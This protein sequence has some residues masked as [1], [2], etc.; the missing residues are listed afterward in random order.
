M[1][2][3]QIQQKFEAFFKER[4]H[5]Y[6]DGSII[7][8]VYQVDLLDVMEHAFNLALEVAADNAEANV[9]ILTEEGQYEMDSAQV[10][11]D[12]EVYVLKNSILKFK[13]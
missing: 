13:L 6:P 11:Y 3:E 7:G 2:K 5:F 9:T 4:F 10:G 1:N 12:Y 8:P